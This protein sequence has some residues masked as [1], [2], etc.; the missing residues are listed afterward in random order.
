MNEDPLASTSIIVSM[1]FYAF[2]LF[3]QLDKDII[4]AIRYPIFTLN[5]FVMGIYPWLFIPVV[6]ISC[7]ILKSFFHSP[8][9]HRIKECENIDLRISSKNARKMQKK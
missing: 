2:A 6:P 7:E 1:P 4:R 8:F 5:F 3:R 9:K